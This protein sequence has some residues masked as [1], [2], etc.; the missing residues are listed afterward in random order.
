[1]RLF[2]ILSSLCLICL[3]VNIARANAID[4][5][6][7]SITVDDRERTYRFNVPG[8]YQPGMLTPPVL[9]F[10]GGGGN[11][12]RFETVARF[13]EKSDASGTIV[14]YP[15]AIDGHW[16]DGRISEMF[17]E[18]NA[19]IDDVRYVLTLIQVLRD[20]F[21]IDTARNFA[22]GVSNGGMFVQRLAIE[23]AEIFARVASIISSIPEPLKDGFQPKYAGIR[24]V[25]QWHG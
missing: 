23:L 13:S 1:M 7:R 18:H 3:S 12:R 4:T 5:Q 9:V 22:A 10:H 17:A 15:N 25:Y 14:V 19:A 8:S 2:A 11:A 21:A 6:E 24:A 20:K 16:N